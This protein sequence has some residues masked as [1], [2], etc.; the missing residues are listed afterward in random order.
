MKLLYNARIYPFDVSRPLA[1][2]IAIERDR[3]LAVDE[4]DPLLS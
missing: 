4:T 2:A 1:H 3:I